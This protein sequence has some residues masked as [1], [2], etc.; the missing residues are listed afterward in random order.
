MSGEMMPASEFPPITQNIPEARIATRAA[1][2]RVWV[3]P[4]SRE[5]DPGKGVNPSRRNVP[6]LSR[7]RDA[8]A[9]RAWW[10]VPLRAKQY[11]R[12]T[13]NGGQYVRWMWVDAGREDV[14][15]GRNGSVY[16]AFPARRQEQQR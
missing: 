4:L 3:D 15:V 13:E 14:L 11:E 9:G 1:G 12:W 5:R 7:L 2:S 10:S 8:L 16:E 6:P